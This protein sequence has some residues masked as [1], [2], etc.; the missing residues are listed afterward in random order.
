M[1][2]KVISYLISLL[3]G[4]LIFSSIAFASDI[5]VQFLPLKFFVNGEQK[6]ILPGQQ[7]FIHDGRTYV[8]LRF[9]AESLGC[10]VDWDRVNSSIY[11]T[12]T[13]DDIPAVPDPNDKKVCL[14]GVWKTESGSIY[15]LKQTDTTITGT[16]THYAD[17]LNKADRSN[18]ADK[19]N[20]V[21]Q[22]NNIDQSKHEFP[23]TGRVEDKTVKLT[24]IYDDAQEYANIKDVPLE[25]AE[26]VVGI[27]ETVSLTL[28]Q[29]T[30]ILEGY[31]YQDYVQW[32][33]NTHRVSE[34]ADGNSQLANSKLPP[35]KV[36][37]FLNNPI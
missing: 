22:S 8:P 20:A 33:S 19:Q 26:Q 24:W 7:A 31:Y 25:V 35:L 21:N 13:P 30:N 18:D 15:K 17:K 9:I 37:L 5:K 32:D 29:E 14:T 12:I 16:F 34:K 11:M 27:S 4:G 2:C 3:M 6:T 28:N 10:S 23:L 36:K 1:K